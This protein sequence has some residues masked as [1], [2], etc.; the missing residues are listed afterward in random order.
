MKYMMR[1]AYHNMQKIKWIMILFEF[2]LVFIIQNLVKGQV[3]VDQ[4]EETPIQATFPLEIILLD[5]YMFKVDEDVFKVEKVE[6]V[7]DTQEDYNITMHFDGSR[8]EQGGGTKVVFFT[9]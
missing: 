5:Q 9:P 4:L 2:D 3:I 6:E 8:C 1:K 7:L